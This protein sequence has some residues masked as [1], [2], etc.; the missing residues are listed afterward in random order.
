[1]VPNEPRPPLDR[2]IPLVLFLVWSLLVAGALVATLDSLRTSD[3]D[4]LNNILQIPFALPW[5]LLP[6]PAMKSWSY[7]TDAWAVAAMGWMNGAILGLL[8]KR[9]LATRG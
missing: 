2:W 4:G 9:R 5:F 6:L 8:L 1:M 3:F 7:E